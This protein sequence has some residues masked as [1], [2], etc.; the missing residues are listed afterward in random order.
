MTDSRTAYRI[1]QS[2]C[3]LALAFAAHAVHAA[4]IWQINPSGQ[5]LA[6]A[7]AVS[8]L[9]VGGVGFVQIQPTSQTDFTFVEHGAYRVALAGTQEIT[10]TYEVSG[11]GLFANPFALHFNTG[12][13]NLYADPSFD[14]ASAAG[15]YGA[16]NGTPLARFSIFAGGVAN[17]GMVSLSA[18]LTPGSLL[19]GYLFDAAGNDLTNAD[20]V[21]MQ[22]GIFNQTTVPDDL[23]VAEIVCGL[24]GYGGAGCDGTPYANSPSAFT[25]RDGG[26]LSLSVVPEPG[27]AGLL[28]AGLG[29]I[30]LVARRRLA[31]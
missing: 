14:F 20:N 3:A 25:V 13:I 18:R 6:G 30:P 23:L 24:A 7:S 9:E 5:G 22:L 2:L 17:T 31:G 1:K 4:P 10:V 15:T 26:T 21:L 27:T 28:L 16:D 29:M 19:S 12:S 11:S 8:M